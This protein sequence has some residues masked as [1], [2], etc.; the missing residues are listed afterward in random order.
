MIAP[1]RTA[2]TWEV[3]DPSFDTH[4]DLTVE[5]L[6]A[7]GRWLE[8]PAYSPSW[9]CLLFSDIPNDRV[10]RWDELSGE[11]TVFQSPAGFANG[12]TIDRLGRVVTCE[13]GERR[14]T[15]TEHDGSVR[16]VADRWEGRQ[17]NS[18]N[19]IVETADGSLWF[20]DP[21]YG[22]DSDYEGH[23]ADAEIGG[24]H[25]YR[26]PP[27]GEMRR[28]LGD[29]E[30]PNGL[31][32]SA[33]EQQLFVVDTRRRHVRRFAVDRRGALEDLGVLVECDAGSYDGVR[34]DDRGRLWLA[35][36]DGL[37]CVEPETGQIVGKLL[38]PEICSNLTFGG[39]RGNRLFVTA[40][41]SIYSLML[42]IRGGTRPMEV[43]VPTERIS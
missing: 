36:H 3:R 37:H 8:G 23:R 25:L 19:D 10:L 38:L 30:R 4:G 35:A 7:A 42:N 27:R 22:I 39:P 2:V 1:E 6:F 13:Q 16:V 5:R 12:R 43:Q 9:R 15:R 41:T 18:P 20:T 26:V 31:A 28:V 11:T 21:S 34:L 29:F 24:C 40:T 33:D 32:F 14:V 17:F